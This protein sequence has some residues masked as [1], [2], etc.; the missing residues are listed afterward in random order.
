M[1]VAFP[2]G[3]AGTHRPSSTT[4]RH[5][6][7][8]TSGWY[9]HAHIESDDAAPLFPLRAFFSILKARKTGRRAELRHTVSGRS[10]PEGRHVLPRVARRP[11]R[12]EARSRADQERG[13]G[14]SKTRG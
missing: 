7:S 6:S 8:S 10:R 14:F 3:H 9:L 5:A 11:E 4:R 13:R 1:N 2:T 12:A